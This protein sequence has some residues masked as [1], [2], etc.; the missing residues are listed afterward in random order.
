[1]V[2]LAVF[3]LVGTL[4]GGRTVCETLAVPFGRAERIAE[5]ERLVDLEVAVTRARNRG[6][7]EVSDVHDI[8]EASVRFF[9]T[10]FEPPGA[11]EG[12][13][14]EHVRARDLPPT[15]EG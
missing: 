9:A 3:D 14:I 7:A 13:A 6:A 15:A 11:D 4:L 10:I 5:L 1:M 12:L 8:D 2:R